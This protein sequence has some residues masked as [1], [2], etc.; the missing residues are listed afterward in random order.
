MTDILNFLRTYDYGISLAKGARWTL[1]EAMDYLAAYRANH[2][3]W[4]GRQ[5]EYNGF[6]SIREQLTRAVQDAIDN[7]WLHIDEAYKKSG[8]DESGK[9]DSEIDF[10]K[11][12]ILPIVFI[13]WAI[14]SNISLPRQ[15]VEYADRHKSDKSLYYEKLGVKKTT[16]HHERCRAVAGLLWSIEPDIPIAEMARRREIVEFGC[17][18]HEYDMRTISRWLASLK[19]DRKPGQPRKKRVKGCSLWLY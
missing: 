6:L 7:G 1:E 17:E 4:L 2:Q 3:K 9:S 10:R 16:V 8:N 13:N 18:G 19:P 15:Y 12:T 11:S 5:D 14:E